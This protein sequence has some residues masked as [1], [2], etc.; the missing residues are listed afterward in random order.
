MTYAFMLGFAV[1]G[2]ALGYCGIVVGMALAGWRSRLPS[3]IDAWVG[4]ARG[5]VVL[6]KLFV[7]KTARHDD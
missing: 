4:S 3:R 2:L 7:N 5:R 1:G 6:D